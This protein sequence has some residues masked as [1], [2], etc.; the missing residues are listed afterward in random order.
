M[1]LIMDLEKKNEP[2]NINLDC[3]GHGI[4]LNASQTLC[5]ITNIPLI[6]ADLVPEDDLHWR[7]LLLL[8]NIINIVFLSPKG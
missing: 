4:G 7:L 5:L 2:T 3:G 6:F 1:L 8:L